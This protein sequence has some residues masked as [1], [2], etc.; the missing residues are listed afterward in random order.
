MTKEFFI[1]KANGMYCRMSEDC[2]IEW[3][4]NIEEADLH[5]DEQAARDTATYAG[6]TSYELIPVKPQ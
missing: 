2:D 3:T 6:F 4:P 1:L 5:D